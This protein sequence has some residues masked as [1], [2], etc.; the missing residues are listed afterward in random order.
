MA[1][2]AQE[3][4]ELRRLG[5]EPA[6]QRPQTPPQPQVQPGERL[7]PGVISTIFGDVTTPPGQSLPDLSFKGVF[8]VDPKT[9]FYKSLSNVNNWISILPDIGEMGG[10][11]AAGLQTAR[12]VG[13]EGLKGF[14]QGKGGLGGRLVSGASRSI[15]Y[16]M[17]GATIGESLR[18]IF[19]NENDPLKAIDKALESGLFGSAG[20][21]ITL[22]DTAGRGIQRIRDGQNYTAEDI[23]AIDELV[24]EMAK[25]GITITPA[26]LIRSGF[27]QTMEKIAISGFGGEAKFGEL[28][29]AQE[30]FL[31]EYMKKMVKTTG[32]PDRKFTGEQFQSALQAMDD[33]LIKWAEPRFAELERR[34]EGLP[35]DLTQIVKDSNDA[36]QKGARSGKKGAQRAMNSEVESLHMF[37]RGR[38][39]NNTFAGAFDVVKE[40][41]GRLREAQSRTSA[42]AKAPNQEYVRELTLTI[43]SLLNTMGDAA[44]ATGNKDIIDLYK[45]TV[46]VYRRVSETANASALSGIATT[47]PEFVGEQLY[48]SG[49]V[50]SVEAAF[51]AIDESVEAAKL[52]GKKGDDLPDAETLK[53]NIRAGYLRELFTP[54]QTGELSTERAIRLLQELNESKAG[55]TFNAVLTPKQIGDVKRALGWGRQLEQQ[56]AGNFSLI[57]RGRQSGA[58]N[59]VANQ[60]GNITQGQGLSGVVVAT[61]ATLMASPLFLANRAIKGDL[62]KDY[63]AKLKDYA[64]K[65]DTGKMDAGDIGQFLGFLAS[66]LSEDEE[67]PMELRVRGLNSKEALELHQLRLETTSITGEEEMG[68]SF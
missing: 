61:A 53:N 55:D 68:G 16:A 15:F 17:S 5:G 57:V 41:K 28:Y 13:K 44:S 26:Q 35:I 40:L 58:F 65:F 18:Q 34:S 11:I 31:R 43:E 3:A 67:I 29:E 23:K 56:A 51:K 48:R 52:A 4:A 64:V 12:E 9:E 14:V 21:F 33:D 54:I 59:Q 22:F 20:E 6:P 47:Q 50:S 8:G 60:I 1:L 32:N 45:D 30:T 25:D 2:S 42:S 36:L 7:Q 10:E 46:D 62:T 49:N 66:D 37:L 38:K 24:T 27:Q 19:Q 39:S 63:L